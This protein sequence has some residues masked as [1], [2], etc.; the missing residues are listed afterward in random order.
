MA[1]PRNHLAL[2]QGGGIPQKQIFM[3]CSR[4]G[5]TKAT[6]RKIHVLGKDPGSTLL[7]LVDAHNLPAPYGGEF[8]WKYGDE[9]NLDEETKELLGQ[10]PKGP[11]IFVNG[12]TMAVPPP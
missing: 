1:Y 4:A 12:A 9:P 3:F 8:E 5:S 10:L 2:D 11:V 7:E 6:R